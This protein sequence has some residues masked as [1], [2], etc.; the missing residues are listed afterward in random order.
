MTSPNGVAKTVCVAPLAQP[1]GAGRKRRLR[2]GPP[3]S[4]PR[5]AARGAAQTRS[6]RRARLEQR[7]AAMEQGAPPQTNQ[8]AAPTELAAR[9]ANGRPCGP[10][11][12]S[13]QDATRRLERP[14]TQHSHTH[15]GSTDSKCDES[16]F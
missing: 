11:N 13:H 4:A 16:L 5:I 7:G 2:R 1:L 6:D 12:T 8:P 15:G 9:R 10:T 14:L 3:H